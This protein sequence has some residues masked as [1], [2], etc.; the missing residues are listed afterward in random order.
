[1]RRTRSHNYKILRNIISQ[2]RQ[3]DFAQGVSYLIINAFLYKYASDL[4]K[5]YFLTVIEDK[6]LS[7]SEAYE[8]N[9]CRQHLKKA[10]LET[11]GYY[12]NSPDC[13]IDEVVNSSYSERFFIYKFFTS[14]MNHMEFSKDSNYE[15]YFNFIF[16][17][18]KRGININKFEFEGENHLIVKEIII[19]I[20][21]LDVMEEAYPFEE[22]FDKI[23]N[24]KLIK[25]EHDPEYVNQILSAIISSTKTG[26][27][28]VYN[29]FFN[30]GSSLVKLKNSIIW[31]NTYG[32]SA[33]KITYC[34]SIVK[35]LLNDFD[36]DRV[37]LDNSSPFESVDINN[38]TFD[39][40]ISKIPPITPRNYKRFNRRQNIERVRNTKR[41]QL[42]NVLSDDFAMDGESL[43]DDAEFNVAIDNL[44]NKMNLEKEVK[45][46]F[47][48]EYESLKDSKYLFL[49]NLINSLNDDGVMAVSMSQSFLSK[50][51][52]QTLRKYLTVEKNYI[53]AVISLPDELSKPR[54][55]DIIIIFKKNRSRDDIVF[56]DMSKNYETLRLQNSVPGLFRR[57]LIFSQKTMHE[58]LDVLYK[59]IPVE[60]FSNVVGLDSLEKNEFNLSIS[61]YVDTF[62]GEFVSLRDLKYQKEELDENLA[63]LNEKIDWML[64][65]LNIR[66]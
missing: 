37:F 14:F 1:M 56:V 19:L 10:A 46:N 60:R 27:V 49:L 3:V 40:I 59:R 25:T 57:N 55:S 51:S 43:V 21:R 63:R 23:C 20:S 11:F 61:R 22:V 53:D 33:D 58:L 44:L 45:L 15:K 18:V 7:L 48:G 36:L 52:L 65:D 2:T 5:D 66:L 13:F 34:A 24:S 6:D 39:V 17:N 35:L 64:S 16:D 47:Y 42:L 4:L 54:P 38:A 32:K 28:D 9:E 50:I 12:I 30:D 62:E 29:P 26:A 8:N 31:Q 41:K